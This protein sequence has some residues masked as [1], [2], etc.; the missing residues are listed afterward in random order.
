MAFSDILYTM[1]QKKLLLDNNIELCNNHKS[2]EN[3]GGECS[4]LEVC[5]L[6]AEELAKTGELQKV[7][8]NIAKKKIILTN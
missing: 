7:S 8:L 4:Y 1:L 3:D 2:K 6:H 5:Y